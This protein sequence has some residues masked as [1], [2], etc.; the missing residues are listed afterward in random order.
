MSSDFYY[1][2]VLVDNLSVCLDTDTAYYHHFKKDEIIKF[3]GLS[4]III[5]DVK[6]LFDRFILDWDKTYSASSTGIAYY[7]TTNKIIDITIKIK[8]E[9]KLKELGL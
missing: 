7:I 1:F 6:H 5:D 3:R 2:Q 4:F 8:R 9:E